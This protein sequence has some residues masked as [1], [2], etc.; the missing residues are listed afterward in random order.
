VAGGVTITVTGGGNN[1]VI[2]AICNVTGDSFVV[3]RAGNGTFAQPE[4]YAFGYMV[5][6]RVQG[7]SLVRGSVDYAP[8]NNGPYVV[9]EYSFYQWVRNDAVTSLF[10]GS[11]VVNLEFNN[12]SADMYGWV[13]SNEIPGVSGQGV[14][15]GASVTGTVE[16]R[17]TRDYLEQLQRVYEW[18]DVVVYSDGTRVETVRANSEFNGAVVAGDE[19]DVV[20]YGSYEVEVSGGEVVLH[21]GWQGGVYGRY[22]STTVGSFTVDFELHNTGNPPEITVTIRDYVLE[23]IDVDVDNAYFPA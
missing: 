9:N 3:P 8:V 10:L 4:F 21:M 11:D 20:A 12:G 17:Y 15:T 19:Y 23:D 22:N 13:R 6:F 18:V 16:F 14:I 7:N 1:L 5:S 2:R